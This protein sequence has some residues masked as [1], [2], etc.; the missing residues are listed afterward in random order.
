MAV[1]A[2][3]NQLSLNSIYNELDDNNYNGGTTN[4]DVSLTN[5]ST[6]GNPP[7][8]SLNTS[9]DAANRP[10]GSAPHAMSEFYSY[11]HDLSGLGIPTNLDYD[12]T[13]TTTVT[14]SFTEGQNSQRVYIYQ[15]GA[16]AING[17][18][19][20]AD[21]LIKNASA[22]YVT[23]NGSGD[24]DVILGDSAGAVDQYGTGGSWATLSLSANDYINLYLKSHDGTSTY[25]SATD[26]ITIWTKVGT[27]TNLAASSVNSSG[28]TISWDEP[29]GGVNA[30]N[31]Y[32]LYFGTDSTATN[33]TS[34][35]QGGTSKSFTG[36]SASTTY[37]F[38]VKA[39]GGGGNFGAIT[40]T[41]DQ[42]TSALATSLAMAKQ[43]YS[44][45]S[46]SY[47]TITHTGTVQT[48]EIGNGSKVSG[49]II[50]RI[51]ISNASGNS[52]VTT[53]ANSGT[54]IEHAWSSNE[55]MSSPST[56][57]DAQNSLLNITGTTFYYHQRVV[58]AS[59]NVFDNV[60]TTFTNNSV[61]TNFVH[62][63]NLSLASD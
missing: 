9:N 12:A 17:A 4:A 2:S 59:S 36:L 3:G 28:M 39:K 21:Q 29:S 60:T 22:D 31:G 49:E 41:E 33:N 20:A 44:R 11:D 38:A 35:D 8:E 57:V 40:S 23:V 13:S 58:N 56:Y 15:S 16:N 48:T 37:Y 19:G 34:Y 5:L 32:R 53:N 47:Q 10:D 7:N 45:G 6:G 54:P 63:W 42:D 46:Y 18:A 26:A 55:D 25:S 43:S 62:D 24:T 50:V 14:L 51:V 61:S 30:S 52:A 1:P 27:P